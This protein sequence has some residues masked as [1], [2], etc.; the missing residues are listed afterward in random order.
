MSPILTGNITNR[1]NRT[2]DLQAKNLFGRPQNDAGSPGGSLPFP[3]FFQLFVKNE[4]K[5]IGRETEIDRRRLWISPPKLDGPE[6]MLEH[7]CLPIVAFYQ[8]QKFD[9]NCAGVG[10]CPNWT[11]PK[12][13]GY[14]FPQIFEG[15]V[16][17]PQKGTFT[18]PCCAEKTPW[19]FFGGDS[20]KYPQLSHALG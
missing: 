19:F 18:N 8:A 6:M 17:N 4:Q 13:W 5:K 7:S 16:Q 20:H 12:Y 2:R 3:C 9:L 10:K 15:D 11:S 14:N 1:T